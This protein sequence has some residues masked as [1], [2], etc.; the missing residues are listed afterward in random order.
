MG[1]VHKVMRASS[2]VVVVLMIIFCCGMIMSSQGIR[3][4]FVKNENDVVEGHHELMIIKGTFGDLDRRSVLEDLDNNN[5]NNNN[6]NQGEADEI[7]V[8]KAVKNTDDIRPTAP[9]HSPGAGHNHG[10]STVPNSK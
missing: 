10:P 4:T 8:S 7:K 5:F 2:L 6:N 9:G 1:P 3:T